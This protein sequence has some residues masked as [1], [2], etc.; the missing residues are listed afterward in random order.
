MKI[1]LNGEW[2]YA[3]VDLNFNHL[4]SDCWK[5][6][7]NIP[8]NWELEGLHDF[9]GTV[10]FK[11][12]ITIEKLSEN[13]R[14]WLRFDGVDYYHELYVNGVKVGDHEGY[15]QSHEFEVTPV[16]REGENEILSKVTSPYEEPGK[17]W[18]ENKR[19]IKGVLNHHDT[20]PGSWDSETGQNKNTGGIWNDVILYSTPQFKLS[21]SKVT[22]IIRFNDAAVVI[23][24][25]IQSL[26]EENIDIEYRITPYN[27]NDENIY[28]KEVNQRIP[29]GAKRFQAVMTIKEPKLWWC[30]DHGY[31][32]LYQLVIQMNNGTQVLKEA[33]IFGIREIKQNSAG[34]VFLNGREI[35]IRG[36]NYIPTQWL[37][38]FTEGKISKDIQ[39][40]KEANIN[41]VRVHAHV[42]RDEFFLACDKNGILVWQDFALQWSYQQNDEFAA[43]A[44]EQIKDMVNQYYNHPSIVIWC[45][46][47]EPSKNSKY[48]DP[49]LYS[50]VKE[51]DSSRIVKES[52]DFTEHVYP[53]WYYG[54]YYEYTALPGAPFVTEFGAQALPNKESME[55]MMDKD[56][57]WPPDWET[58]AYH[59]FQYD[60]TFNVAGISAGNSIEEFISNSQQ[61]QS[62]YLKFAIENYRRNKGKITGLFQFMF[63]D[64]WPSITWSV[65]DYDRNPKKGY[66]TLKQSYEPL[67]ISI[68]MPRKRLNPGFPLFKSIICVNDLYK[69]FENVTLEVTIEDEQGN[70]YF[71]HQGKETWTIKENQVISLIEL[72]V[73]AQPY[74]KVPDECNE[75]NFYIKL[76][77]KQGNRVIA[78]NY[79]RFEVVREVQRFDQT[80]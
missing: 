55:K 49:I 27:F 35:F 73:G 38:E 46:H 45:C 61:Y 78:S 17:I 34:K 26:N 77:L 70:C 76:R 51:E 20:R 71:E 25:E 68:K 4:H 30:W 11:K 12:L 66:Y 69:K 60:E 40:I 15:F 19:L 75:G 53:G 57:L 2:E 9:C 6:V 58:W 28:I 37:S 74:W 18:P 14:Y 36:T 64:C 47:N 79:E 59:D 62:D 21:K 80:F 24:C 65:V 41:A 7:M 63:V 8:S 39:L 3:P 1:Y 16:L 44:V 10:W 22:P 29:R 13:E 33:I 72:G 31:P 23:D 54:S 42:T 43:E 5:G 52:S 56:K 50:A 67:L 32:H 48:L